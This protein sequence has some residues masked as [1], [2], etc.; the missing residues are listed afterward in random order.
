[1]QVKP[2]V[3]GAMLVVSAFDGLEDVRAVTPTSMEEKHD[4]QA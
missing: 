2:G 4:Q 3:R 1:M